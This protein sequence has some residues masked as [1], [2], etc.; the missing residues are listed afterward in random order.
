MIV[1]CS[2]ATPPQRVVINGAD[3]CRGFVTVF[4][5]S[6]VRH[7]TAEPLRLHKRDQT[8]D[9]TRLIQ[10]TARSGSM[11]HGREQ[12]ELWESH[13]K[14]SQH[15]VDGLFLT[16]YGLRL[17]PQQ[18]RCLHLGLTTRWK[19]TCHFR[20]PDTYNWRNFVVGRRCSSPS[21]RTRKAT[22]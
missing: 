14:H 4:S 21:G 3:M 9:S 10:I 16:I 5:R 8:A 13:K 22:R 6:R 18:G 7:S 2:G 11:A 15:S 1:F 12:E 19:Q 17:Q 20:C